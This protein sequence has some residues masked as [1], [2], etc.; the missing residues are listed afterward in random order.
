[1]YALELY[2]VVKDFKGFRLG[3]ISLKLDKGRVYGF[4]GP[5]GAGKTTTIQS[6]FGLMNINEGDIE[7][8][9]T[10][11]DPNKVDW[12]YNVG[13]AGNVNSFYEGWTARKNLEFLKSFYPG[14]DDEYMLSLVSKFEL[15]LEKKVKALSTGNRLK[16]SIISAMS[17]RPKLLLLDEPTSG[18]DPI[19]KTELLDVLFNYMENE[20]NTILYSTHI[21]SEL[22][23]LADELIFI[24]NGNIVER[25]IKDDLAGKWKRVEVVGKIEFTDFNDFCSYKNDGNRT[26]FTTDKPEELK[27]MLNNFPHQIVSESNITLDEAAVE[28]IRRS[29]YVG[30][31]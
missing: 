19:I 15:P 22:E 17:Y 25:E 1:M 5:N 14:W 23:R 31:S 4:I 20:E 7:I 8:Y 29:K 26:I 16:L 13:Y 18:L 12:K 30:I 10:E 21:I 9:G 6:I 2:N 3:P 24:S 28:I 11:T 27:K